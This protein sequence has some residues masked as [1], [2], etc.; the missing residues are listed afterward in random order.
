MNPPAARP[1]SGPVV[2]VVPLSAA[3]APAAL[4]AAERRLGVRRRGGRRR[5]RRGRE[6][7]VR[8]GGREPDQDR[9]NALKRILRGYF[10]YP[11]CSPTPCFDRKL[12]LLRSS[13]G[14]WM[15]EFPPTYAQLLSLAVA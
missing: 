10:Y 13:K 15:R 11:I 6:R 2:V 1:I 7:V 12:R 8:L 9:V 3:A 4:D 14:I 5:V